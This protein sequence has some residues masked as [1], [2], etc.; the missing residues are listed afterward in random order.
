M[1][2]E[3]KFWTTDNFDKTL[4]EWKKE[5]EIEEQDEIKQKEKIL[6]LLNEIVKEAKK[7]D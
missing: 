7:N 4:K 5:K 2:K 6:G 1:D 3:E